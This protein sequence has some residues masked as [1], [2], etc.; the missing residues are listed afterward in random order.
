[1]SPADTTSG[2]R[3]FHDQL[4]TLKQRLLDMSARSE[5][6]VDLAVDALLTRDKEKAD[7]DAD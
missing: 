7:K 4:S 1:M 2:F 3:H 5:E 6:L